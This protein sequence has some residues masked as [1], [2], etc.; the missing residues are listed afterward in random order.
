[1]TQFVRC[2]ADNNVV[3]VW[4]IQ[5]NVTDKNC[6]LNPIQM[7]LPDSKKKSWEIW[8]RFLDKTSDPICRTRPSQ[9]IADLIRSLQH[10]NLQVSTKCSFCFQLFLLRSNVLLHLNLQVLFK[11][12]GFIQ[13]V[14]SSKIKFILHLPNPISTILCRCLFLNCKKWN[15]IHLTLKNALSF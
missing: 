7:F 4:N 11:D 9:E 5:L 14:W 10:S 15:Q 13:F 3:L 6:Q 2:A 12:F 1:M 8:W